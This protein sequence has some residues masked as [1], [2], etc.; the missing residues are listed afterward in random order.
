MSRSALKSLRFS[1]VI[2]SGLKHI[3][4]E[5]TLLVRVGA[6]VHSCV[7]RRMVLMGSAVM[8]WLDIWWHWDNHYNPRYLE[9]QLASSFPF[10]VS[11]VKAASEVPG[12]KRVTVPAS[13]YFILFYLFMISGCSIWSH[14]TE[15][16][17]LRSLVWPKPGPYRPNHRSVLYMAV[18]AHGKLNQVLCL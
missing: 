6:T 15:R 14:L 1:W 16:G 18:F 2:T 17:M 12:S 9:E 3:V 7:S 13:L 10:L 4:A 11:S 8:W 5:K